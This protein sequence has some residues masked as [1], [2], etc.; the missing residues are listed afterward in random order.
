MTRYIIQRLLMLFPVLLG[1]SF[2]TFAALRAAPGDPV[3]MMLGM[4]ASPERIATLREQLGLNDPFLVQYGRFVWNALQGDLGMTFGGQ[5]PVADEIARRLP[6]TLQLTMVG[7]SFAV[8]VG[9]T[10]GT[11]AATHR[12]QWIDRVTMLFSTAGLCLPSFW[13]GII[14]LIIFGVNLRWVSVVGGGELKDLIMPAFALG[15]APAAVIARLSRSSILEVFGEDYVRT[16]RGKG[17]GEKLVILRHVLRNALIPVVTIIG[18][19]FASLMGG[20]VFIESVFAR[21]GLGRLAVGAIATREYPIT[22]GVVLLAAT[23]YVVINLAVDLFY[24]FL[25]PRIHYQ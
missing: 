7:L 8:I 24:A 2:I 10:L 21:P 9:I 18:L 16:A 19:Q 3:I 14:L 6:S 15:L 4:D 5:L 1:V 25:D 23:A 11:I 13:V 17:L 12:G 20:A 22:Q